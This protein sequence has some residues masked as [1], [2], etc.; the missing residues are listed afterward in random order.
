MK[1]K[2]FL[3]ITVVVLLIAAQSLGAC[4]IF[5]VGKDATVDG[6]TMVS[7]TC[8][9][10]SDDFRLWLIP[11][12]PEGTVRDIVVNGRAGGDFSQFP[13]VKDYGPGAMVLGSETY[14]KPTNQYLHSMYS[15][16]NDKG[17]AMG[18]STCTY[19]RSTEQG[20]KLAEVL[21]RD[22][23]ILDCYCLQDMALETCSTA[24]EAVEY[25]GAMIDKYGWNGAAECINI[26][27]GN[28]A[29]V[30]EAY[31]ANVWCAVRVPDNA[32]FVAANRARINYIDF[33]DPENYAWSENIQS[34]ALE[35]G[36]W[37]GVSD[38]EPCNIY[39]YY[40]ENNLGCTLREWRA[41]SLLDSDLE[42]DPFGDPDDYPLFVVPDE[43]VSVNTIHM[44]CSDYYQGTEFDCSR[45]VQSGPF[46]NPISN[47]NVYR[48]INMF[49]CTYIQIANVK[50]WLPEEARCLVWVGWGAPDST[51]LTPIFASVNELPEQFGI[52]ERL[53]PYDE[54]SAWWVAT[55]VQQTATINYDYAID[56]IHGIRDP[57]MASI[58]KTTA[59]IQD[60][61]ASMINVGM[62]DEAVELLTNY[63][64]TVADDWHETWLALDKDLRS[65]L[66]FGNIDMKVPKAS[67]WWTNIVNENLGDK[68]KPIED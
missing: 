56:V 26:C 37:D 1:V 64:T 28:E 3:T 63:T 49:R 34:Y 42:L 30:F 50:S 51:Y 10:N 43:K 48:P 67:D 17:L 4:T 8:D 40:K 13:E 22:E 46:G 5:A 31:G 32:I 33:N 15:F 57:K 41:L 23:G 58:Y 39:A 21:G 68:L 61:A 12:M 35:N 11:S 36:L 53:L 65:T 9:S 54:E 45:T 29:W 66:M 6:S 59:S 16:M 24:R 62:K 52:G 55:G 60:L 20:K 38:F 2:K 47:L 18:E 7:H 19:D 14:D 44:L 27:D 25:M